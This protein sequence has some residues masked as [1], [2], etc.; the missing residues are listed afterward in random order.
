MDDNSAA[1]SSTARDVDVAVI[2]TGFAGLY[3]LY[4]VRE[5]LGLDV[6][7]FDN[8]ADVGG[9]WYSNRYPGARSDTEIF[10]Y[11]YSFDRELF[12]SWEWSERYP[13]GSEILAYLQHVADR[14]DLRRSVKF[15]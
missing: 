12:E 10:A 13:P 11:C 4:K 6:V 15:N 5:D 14:H 8:A 2:G 9:T 1:N 3:S 7:A